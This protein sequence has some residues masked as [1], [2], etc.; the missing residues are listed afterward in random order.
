MTK[1]LLAFVALL[2]L[3]ACSDGQQSAPGKGGTV[4]LLNVSY[5]PT[6]ELYRDINQ[7]FSRQWLADQGQA[8]TFRMSHGGS[9]KQSRAVIDGLE[10]TCHAGAR[11]DV[12]VIANDQEACPR[13]ANQITDIA[14]P[15]PRHS[16]SGARRNPKG[17]RDWVIRGRAS[18]DHPN[19]RTSGGAR[20]FLA[21]GARRAR[22]VG[23]RR[24]ST[25]STYAK[26]RCRQ[27]AAG[28]PTLLTSAA[29]AT[30]DG[31]GK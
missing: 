13:L 28:R 11:L 15:T 12:D 16:C 30:C 8:V 4:T 25:S 19:H 3:S 23:S 18:R 14:R 6:R 20:G 17:L 27:R 26:F 21:A 24:R 2:L 10:P 1:G 7:A 9:G 31:G 5:D 22:R 29:S